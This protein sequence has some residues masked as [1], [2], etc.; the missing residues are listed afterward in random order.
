MICFAYVPCIKLVLSLFSLF[1]VYIIISHCFCYTPCEKIHMSE[2]TDL[3]IN[4]QG[5]T[6]FTH[7]L[8]LTHTHTHRTCDILYEVNDCLFISFTLNSNRQET[9]YPR[10]KFNIQ[11]KRKP[12]DRKTFTSI[13]NILL[14]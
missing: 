10:K 2:H 1:S 9:E 13:K 5:Y 14:F 11:H 4:S 7:S 6:N 3:H 8:T 12:T